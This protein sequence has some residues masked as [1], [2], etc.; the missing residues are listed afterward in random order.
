MSQ[1]EKEIYSQPAVLERLLARESKRTRKIG[2]SIKR[3]AK[4]SAVRTVFMVARGSS[5]NAGLYGKYLFGARNSLVTAMAAPSLFTLYKQ[6]PDLSGCLVLAISQSGASKDLGR[7]LEEARRQGSRTLVITNTP[8]SP[9]ADLADDVIPLHAGVERSVAA[10]KSYTA[11][12]LSLAMLSVAL[13]GSEKDIE[14]LARVPQALQA[15]L[16]GAEP[17]A[18]AAERYRYMQRL[19]VIGRGYNYSTAFELS[20]K[21]KELAY[22]NAEPSSS[23]D[24]RHG[25]IAVVEEGFPVMLIAPSGKTLADMLALA[26]ALSKRRAELIVISDNKRLRAQATTP[27]AY[28]SGLPEWLSPLLAVVPGQLFAMHL[29]A[30]R[31]CPLDKPRGLTKVTVTY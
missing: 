29:A 26:G 5:D 24:F 20:L 11:Q 18:A 31:G 6:P 1:I 7:V 14:K 15:V 17:I 8:G 16:D 28:G 22:L 2:A 13:R 3:S 23:A 10:T 9:L 21:L 27:L 30:A 12:L 19:A 4:R 25:P